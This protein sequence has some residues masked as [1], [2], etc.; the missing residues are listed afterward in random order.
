MEISIRLVFP[1]H[2]LNSHVH[3]VL[4]STDITRRNLML[5]TLRA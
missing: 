3:S 2:V 1:D 4:Q 5:V